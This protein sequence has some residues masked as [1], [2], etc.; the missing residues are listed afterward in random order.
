MRN[1]ASNLDWNDTLPELGEW[2]ASLLGRSM[3]E[4]VNE[5]LDKMLRP[6]FGYQG[7]QLGQIGDAE[8]LMGSAGLLRRFVLGAIDSQ[9]SVDLSATV[10]E[11]PIAS[12]TISL[13]VMPHTLE[14]CQDPHQVLREAD[15]VLARD[16]YLL[17]IGFNPLSTWGLARYMR[18]WQRS[19]PW[20]GVFYSRSRINDWLSLLNFRVVDNRKF[21]LRPPIGQEQLLSKLAFLE[22]LQ[23]WLG[24]FGAA[25]IVLA[26]KQVRPLTPKLQRWRQRQSV[27]ARR[28]IEPVNKMH[29]SGERV[30]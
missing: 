30:D 6:V 3:L 11:L 25:Y 10:L 17:L 14:F 12:D 19:A 20:N 13:L 9:A 22:R 5:H 27:V 29:K 8:N 7:L 24:V 23:P 1:D 2:Y 4:E 21:Y 26:R 18:F 16:G 28:I 15:R